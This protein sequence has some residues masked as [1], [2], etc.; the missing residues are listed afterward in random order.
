MPETREVDF[1][2][3]L[4]ACNTSETY[5]NSKLPKG[6]FYYLVNYISHNAFKDN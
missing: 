2:D 4:T 1:K 5:P 6:L 3:I